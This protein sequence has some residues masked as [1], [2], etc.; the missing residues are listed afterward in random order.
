MVLDDLNRKGG[1]VRMTI[2]NVVK[3]QF[4]GDEAVQR[5][6]RLIGIYGVLRC[7]KVPNVDTLD[8][9]RPKDNPTMVFLSPVGTPTSPD[10]GEDAFDA[11]ACVLRALKVRYHSS[12]YIF[13]D[14]VLGDA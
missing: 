11:V 5:V 6:T 1:A 7:K 13:S 4:I 3:K 12:V 14:I 10:D 2:G 8:D 9:F